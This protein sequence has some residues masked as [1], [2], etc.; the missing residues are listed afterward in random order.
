MSDLVERL[1]SAHRNSTQRCNGS[2]IFLDAASEIK[3]L[4]FE[5]LMVAKAAA[6]KP[7]FLNPLNAAHAKKIRDRVLSEAQVY[8]TT[9]T[10][11]K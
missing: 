5:L 7:M 10:E 9:T 3:K 4:R 8:G 11:S 6:D 2:N 1:E